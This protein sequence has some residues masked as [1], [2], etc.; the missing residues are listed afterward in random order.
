[1]HRWWVFFPLHLLANYQNISITSSKNNKRWSYEINVKININRGKKKTNEN[2]IN[3][4][5]FVEIYSFIIVFKWKHYIA[6]T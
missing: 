2:E 4:C 6:N 5:F 1:M 3:L